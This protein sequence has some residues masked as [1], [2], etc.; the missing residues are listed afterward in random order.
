ME[1]FTRLSENLLATV[2]LLLYGWFVPFIRLIYAFCERLREQKKRR[3]EVPSSVRCVTIPKTIYKRPDP[4]IYS[5]KYLMSQGLA[6][7]WDNPD[8][9]LFQNGLPV[10][11][12]DLVADTV[13][14]IRA[15]IWNGSTEAAAIDMPVDFSFLTFGIGTTSTGIGRTKVDLPVKGAAGHP[16]TATMTWRT[17]PV[18]GHYCLQVNLIW[19]DDNNPYNNLG[20]EN[21]DVGVARS[22]AVFEFPVQNETDRLTSITLE[23]D[24]Y[25]LPNPVDCQ[26][27]I[28]GRVQIP[29]RETG[30]ET[31]P[32]SLSFLK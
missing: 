7:T 26:D 9:T 21:T 30:T 15:T 8:I 11:S 2:A 10:S 17:P 23:A 3:N 19:G 6:V 22:P 25:T 13:Y 4:L 20:Q 24:T 1:W 18:A 29:G 28:N 31:V 27:V 16:A 32:S 14:E 5:Q 12:S